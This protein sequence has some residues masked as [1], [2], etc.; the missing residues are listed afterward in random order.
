VCV[1]CASVCAGVRAQMLQP[2]HPDVQT[3]A[4]CSSLVCP[5]TRHYGVYPHPHMEVIHTHTLTYTP[6]PS[7][8][9]RHMQLTTHIRIRMRTHTHTLELAYINATK[10]T[11]TPTPTPSNR[12]AHTQ[13]IYTTKPT[14]NQYTQPIYTTK[15]TTKIHNQ[16]HVHAHICTH[17][18]TPAP[19]AAHSCA[20][21]PGTAQCSCFPGA[22]VGTFWRPA[23]GQSRG[24]ACLRS[25]L[26]PKIQCPLGTC[27]PRM[28]CFHSAQHGQVCGM[29][30]CVCVCV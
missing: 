29:Y 10:P 25:P 24:A 3:F 18:P 20:P 17:T 2:T 15:Y 30:E 11:P 26:H 9:L 22:S 27:L 4:A 6:T 23:P 16:T 7:F 21:A 8:K 14:S 1:L 13:P 5:T 12:H 19:A 28:S